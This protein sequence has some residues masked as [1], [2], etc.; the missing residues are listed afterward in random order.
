MDL[1]S[2]ARVVLRAVHTHHL[3]HALVNV[4]FHDPANRRDAPTNRPLGLLYVEHTHRYVGLMVS[5]LLRQQV[6]LLFSSSRLCLRPAS[7][8]I[9][10]ARLTPLP[11]HGGSGTLFLLLFGLEVTTRR[12]SRITELCVA[13]GKLAHR[14]Y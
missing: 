9:H 3:R 12:G 2:L 6:A 8:R 11:L 4:S 5:L 13:H 10:T 14:T 1:G 7:F